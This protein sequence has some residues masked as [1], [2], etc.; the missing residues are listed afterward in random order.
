MVMIYLQF[1]KP[2]IVLIFRYLLLVLISYNFNTFLRTFVSMIALNDYYQ[3]SRLRLK[4]VTYV[5]YISLIKSVGWTGTI[6]S[7]SDFGTRGPWFDARQ[8]ESSV[9]ALNKSNFH[10]SVLYMYYMNY[11]FLVS[12]NKKLHI[13]YVDC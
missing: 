7:Q 2:N 10:S 11:M 13:A 12:R 4:I 1:H 3:V 6:G 9:V 8:G 5:A